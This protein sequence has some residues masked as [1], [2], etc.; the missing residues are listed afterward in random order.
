[1][2]GIDW[3]GAKAALGHVFWIGGGSEAGKSTISR[4]LAEEFD[5]VYYHGDE[6]YSRHVDLAEKERTPM[7][8]FHHQLMREERFDQ[9]FFALSPEE[10]AQGGRDAGA[11]DL[12]M[13]I[14][15]LLAMPTDKRIVVDVFCAHAEG[16]VQVTEIHNLV[17]LVATDSFQRE[18]IE[19]LDRK[20]GQDPDENYIEAQRLF[21]EGFRGDANRLGIP[22]VV[23]GGRLTLDESYSA[24]CRHFGLCERSKTVET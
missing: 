2:S 17:F 20:R 10:K 4:R 23:T 7:L 12:L 6:A 15:D 8:W 24:V 3:E 21:S 5:F 18:T 13:V 22:M 16:L 1:M 19:N 11:E 14:D 9:W